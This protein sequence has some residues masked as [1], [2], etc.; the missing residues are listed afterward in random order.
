MNRT[1]LAVCGAVVMSAALVGAQNKPSPETTNNSG[2]N[3]NTVTFTG[4]LNAGSSADSYYLTNAKRKGVKNAD[5]TLKIVPANP[6]V[7]LEQFLTQEIEVTGPIDP[8]DSSAG[9]DAPSAARTV[10]VT[11][12]K[13][14]TQSCG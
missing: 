7:K 9:S 13:F 8:P 14:R 11:K 4:C 3:A 1:F 12:V 5:K 2:A 6:K 10:T